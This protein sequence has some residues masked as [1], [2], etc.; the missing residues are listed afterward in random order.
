M[1][2]VGFGLMKSRREKELFFFWLIEYYPLTGRKVWLAEP[3]RWQRV[4]LWQQ[5]QAEPL[6]D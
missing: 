3:D 2:V 6:G 5:S 4:G 1:K